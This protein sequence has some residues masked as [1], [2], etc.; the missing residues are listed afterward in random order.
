MILT[1]PQLLKLI[2]EGMIK[3][4]GS[5]DQVNA[6]SVD[7]RLGP[8][9]LVEERFSPV[10]PIVDL[11]SREPLG[12]SSVKL[13][14]SDI[15]APENFVLDP[16]QFVL[17]ATLERFTLPDNVSAQF[18]LTSSMARSGLGH[19][20]A[21]H[22]NPGWNNS[23]LTLELKNET[24]FHSLL[25]TPGMVIG[26][27]VFHIHDTVSKEASYSSRGKYNKDDNVRSTK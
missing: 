27:M 7:V 24:Q 22:C 23:T 25:L 8:D 19:S 10:Y 3:N 1:H 9:F 12:M 14:G 6:S 21:G 26:Q 11:A 13:E 16:G 2:E 15:Q 4:I 20:L 18:H 17:G 5:L